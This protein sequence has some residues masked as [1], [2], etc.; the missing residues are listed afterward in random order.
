MVMKGMLRTE[1]ER[2]GDGRMAGTWC[3]GFEHLGL[4]KVTKFRTVSLKRLVTTLR[5]G[6]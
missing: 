2:R 5:E 3:S 1:L 4:R 6:I